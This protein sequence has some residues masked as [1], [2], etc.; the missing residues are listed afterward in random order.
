MDDIW[1]KGGTASV[2]SKASERRFGEAKRH[3]I[4]TVLF[5]GRIK[6]RS[7]PQPPISDSIG[8]VRT[9]YL[10]ETAFH[11]LIVGIPRTKLFPRLR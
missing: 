6:L 7:M 3:G 9:N 5:F 8:W 11:G 10:G 1:G 2:Y 4:E